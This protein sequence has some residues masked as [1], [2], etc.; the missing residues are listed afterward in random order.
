[1]LSQEGAC[2][3]DFRTV[4][5]AECTVKLDMHFHTTGLAELKPIV[6]IFIN[7]D[8]KMRKKRQVAEEEAVKGKE[9]KNKKENKKENAPLWRLDAPIF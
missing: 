1:M 2:V 6:N 9:N 7:K 3:A 5:T 8:G 4:Q